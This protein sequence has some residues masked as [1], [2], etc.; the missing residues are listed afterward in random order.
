MFVITGSVAYDYLMNYP[1]RF[2]DHLIADQL[3][4][5]SLSFLADSMRRERGG[6]A[7]NIAYTNKLLGG[8]PV[9][10]ATVGQDFGDYRRWMEAQGLNTS[11]IVEI[12]DVFTASF[13]CNTDLDGR[14]IASF[15]S[16]AML[17]ARE[18]SLRSRGLEAAS[19]VLISPNDPTAMLNYATE[20]KE[21]GVPFAYDPSQQ[22]ARLSGE[23]LA[24][25]VPGASYLF[26][27][28]YELAI[29]QDKTGWDL[30][31]VKHKVEMLVL[32]LAE[33][34]SVIYTDFGAGEEVYIPA[35]KVNKFTDP[36]GAGDAYRGGFFAARM[37]E[38]PL[39]VCG[40]IGALCAVYSLENVGP[41]EHRFT[42]DEFIARYA[43]NFGQE[44]EIERLRD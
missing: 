27:N 41:T 10:F 23:D 14:Q 20:C 38:L 21:L 37:A 8:N 3:D 43:E 15:Y 24:Q 4:N 32:T 26:C 16:G 28:E 2:R 1:G 40:R 13:F 31:D 19:L 9:V 17:H 42:L 33:K 39:E 6:V 7:G 11:Q 30:N 34:G 44:P 29:I 25:S 22:V 12:P 36:T 18:H 35:A 5:V